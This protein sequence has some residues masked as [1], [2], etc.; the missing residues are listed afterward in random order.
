M[1]SS[2]DTPNPGEQSDGVSAERPAM[3]VVRL[4]D[5]AHAARPRYASFDEEARIRRRDGARLG[6]DRRQNALF[7][8]SFVFASL[9]MY[10]GG[11]LTAF[12]YLNPADGLDRAALSEPVSEQ[13]SLGI[14]GSATAESVMPIT[15]SREIAAAQA[16]IGAVT[17]APGALVDG[18]P[19]S[20]SN[21]NGT[22]PVMEGAFMGQAEPLTRRGG[23]QAADAETGVSAGATPPAQIAAVSPSLN[24]AVSNQAISRQGS[25]GQGYSGPA[26]SGKAPAPVAV[27]PSTALASLAQAP[28]VLQFGAFGSRTNA[29][30][31]VTRLSGLI[32]APRIYESTGSNGAPLYHVLGGAFENET[33]AKRVAAALSNEHRLESIVRRAPEAALSPSQPNAG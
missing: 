18:L 22:G 1:S 32:E 7:V 19:I 30:N 16:R 10:A 25:S 31:M 13:Q 14:V 24:E 27:K 6:A 33:A 23:T 12:L 29:N 3:G 11:F 9:F 8:V 20:R 21:D 2:F 26:P 15:P 4:L 28:I 17:D 5:S